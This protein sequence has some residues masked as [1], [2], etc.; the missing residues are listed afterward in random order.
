MPR[1][2]ML[3]PMLTIRMDRQ[4]KG[5]EGMD[6]GSSHLIWEGHLADLPGQIFH[7]ADLLDA[8]FSILW[9]RGESLSLI[10]DIK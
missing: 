4:E 5:Q 10:R 6:Q 2:T 9:W 1:I 3:L 7:P 8:D